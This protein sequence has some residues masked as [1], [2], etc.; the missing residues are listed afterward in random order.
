L[1]VE[2]SSAQWAREI[3]RSTRTILARLQLLLGDN[4]VKSITVRHA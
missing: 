1:I 3:K 2:V 4:T